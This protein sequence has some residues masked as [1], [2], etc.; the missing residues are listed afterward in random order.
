[1]GVSRRF[2]ESRVAVDDTRSRRVDRLSIG[3]ENCVPCEHSDGFQETEL[4][5]LIALI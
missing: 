5:T 2:G 3:D 1:M 4:C